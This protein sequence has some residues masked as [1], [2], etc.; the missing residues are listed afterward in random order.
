MKS[1][2]KFEG[3]DFKNNPYKE[4]AEKLYGEKVVN[5]SNYYIKSLGLN[6]QEKLK[7]EFNNLFTSLSKLKNEDPKS[8]TS[9]KAMEEMHSFFNKNF[10]Y[11]YSLEAFKSLGQMYVEDEW[12]KNNIDKFSLGLAKYLSQAMAHYVNIKLEK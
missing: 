5:A 7:K 11:H 9:I 4:E 8:K 3:F 10:G 1:K 12:F 6:G 2:E